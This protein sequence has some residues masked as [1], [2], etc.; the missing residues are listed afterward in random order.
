MDDIKRRYQN[1]SPQAVQNLGQV[2][3]DASCGIELR[4]AAAGALA[5]MHTQQSL[6]YMARLLEDSDITLRSMGVG[7]ISSFANNVPVGSHEPA[8]G[9]WKYRTDDTIAHSAF[10]AAIVGSNEAYYVGFWRSWWRQ[11]QGELA[12]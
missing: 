3:T 12:Q 6:A 5:R 7:G 4:V 1:T 11:Y 9:P 2:A 8:P 10:D